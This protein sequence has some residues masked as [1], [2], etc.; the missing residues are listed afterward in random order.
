[1][2]REELLIADKQEVSDEDQSKVSELVER[3]SLG[4]PLAYITGTKHFFGIEF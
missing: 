4:E 3:R 1:M 2:S